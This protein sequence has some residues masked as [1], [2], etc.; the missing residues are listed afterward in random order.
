MQHNMSMSELL[1]NNRGIIPELMD[2]EVA[3]REP[4]IQRILDQMATLNE[5][6]L[7]DSD[8]ITEEDIVTFVVDL[9][10]QWLPMLDEEM[11]ISGGLRIRKTGD[12]RHGGCVVDYR[13]PGSEFVDTIVPGSVAISK[14]VVAEIGTDNVY[15]FKLIA[16]MNN[17]YF[18][19]DDGLVEK[20]EII[21]IDPRYAEVE[22]DN[23]VSPER[24]RAWLECY[25]P[26]ILA[27]IDVRVFSHDGGSAESILCLRDIDISDIGKDEKPDFV[28]KL[29]SL[30]INSV[31]EPDV[32]LPYAFI[33]N[34]RAVS[35][36]DTTPQL[37]NLQASGHLMALES[38]IAQK[39]PR[40]KM[41]DE[42]LLCVI[43][44]IHGA[45]FDSKL[46]VC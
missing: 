7:H 10:R 30:Y 36:L 11:I 22:F 38:I 17:T 32:Q 35:D 4:V 33:F 14:G 18:D 21:T 42:W 8:N 39:F 19:P 9:D 3:T 12:V 34:G 6:L 20:T 16:Q 1:D 45:S 5:I 46:K 15:R 41:P 37:A 28:A 40:D 29:L 23:V 24:A 13:E 27:E 26:D 44:A 43:G 25:Y 31:V 2:L